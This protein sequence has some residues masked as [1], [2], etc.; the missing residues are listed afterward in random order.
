MEPPAGHVA[1]HQTD[2]ASVVSGLQQVNELVNNDVLEALRRLLGELG[3]EAD[4]ARLRVV[5]TLPR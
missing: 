2:E 4:G 5:A 3:V 1:I